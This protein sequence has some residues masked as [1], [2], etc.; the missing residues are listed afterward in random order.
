MERSD[1]ATPLVAFSALLKDPWLVRGA[2]TL[3]KRLIPFSPVSLDTQWRKE[4]VDLDGQ[5]QQT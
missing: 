1:F 2:L 3:H 4:L 5:T